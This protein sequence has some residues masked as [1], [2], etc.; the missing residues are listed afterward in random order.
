MCL[1]ESIMYLTLIQKEN[2]VAHSFN[3]LQVQSQ[4][5]LSAAKC[6]CNSAFKRMNMFMSVVMAGIAVFV[7]SP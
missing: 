4:L 6:G 2:S 1:F 5:R 7:L 3:D